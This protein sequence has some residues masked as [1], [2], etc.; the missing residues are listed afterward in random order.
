[1]AN[2]TPFVVV[3]HPRTGS[4]LL[5]LALRQNPHICQYGELFHDDADV[6]IDAWAAARQEYRSPRP[7]IDLNE[8]ARCYLQQTTFGPPSLP[9]VGAIGFKLLYEQARTTD[10][11]R[12]VWK[13]LS[14]NRHVRVVHLHREN[15]LECL[16][17]EKTAIA[18]GIWNIPEEPDNTTALPPEIQIIP[19]EP[20][21]CE[22]Y[23]VHVNHRKSEIR[24]LFSEHKVLD[25]EYETDLNR[26]YRSTVERAQTF[27]G[28]PMVHTEKALKKQTDM[29]IRERVENWEQLEEHFRNTEF[30]RHFEG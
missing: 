1:M 3:A 14:G 4:T 23:F 5:Q 29:P 2:L 16:V 8:C 30:A 26:G 28:V 19:L 6:R 11:I 25:L 20:T 27:L 13:F 10:G 17:S 9:G 12:S 15:L 24:T 18:S 7:Y 22:Q 21:E